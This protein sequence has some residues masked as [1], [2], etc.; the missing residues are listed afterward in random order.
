MVKKSVVVRVH[1]KLVEEI[2]RIKRNVLDATGREIST[3]E[4]SRMIRRPPISFVSD[5]KPR[6]RGFFYLD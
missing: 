3:Y 1:P 5:R 4:A 2:E 6:K